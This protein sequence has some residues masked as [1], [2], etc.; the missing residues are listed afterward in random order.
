MW[1]APLDCHEGGR[2]PPLGLGVN[3]DLMNY[4]LYE[5]F[6]L[7]L[8]SIPFTFLSHHIEHGFVFQIKIPCI[9]TMLSNDTPLG[10]TQ[11]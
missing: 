7:I 6:L 10:L 2:T 4:F 9:I 3:L 8:A 11:W 1:H 5:I